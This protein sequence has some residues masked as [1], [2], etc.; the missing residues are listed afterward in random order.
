MTTGQMSMKN[1]M[2]WSTNSLNGDNDDIENAISER[3]DD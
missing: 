3:S 1:W 2:T